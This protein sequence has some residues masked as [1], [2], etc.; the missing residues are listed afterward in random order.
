[1][2]LLKYALMVLFSAGMMSCGGGGGDDPVDEKNPTANI[3]SPGSVVNSGDVF[4][5]T[6]TADDDTGLESYRV[7]IEK[8]ANLPQASMTKSY[9][10]VFSFDSNSD[11]TDANDKALPKITKGVKKAKIDF[12]LSTDFGNHEVAQKG[13]YTLKVSLVD[14]SGKTSAIDKEFQIQ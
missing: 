14:V 1:M 2:K 6:F 4:N 5:I 12:P 11:L 10:G 9:T 13:V 3:T 8:T 7:Q